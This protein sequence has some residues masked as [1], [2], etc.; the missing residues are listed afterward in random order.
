MFLSGLKQLSHLI[1]MFN[2]I[3]S[4]SGLVVA[5]A[6]DYKS[7]KLEASK[8]RRQ[9]YIRDWKL[10]QIKK[11]KEAPVRVYHDDSGCCDALRD[12]SLEIYGRLHW[13]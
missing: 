11:Q 1:Q 10:V 6:S 8:Y 9:E 5:K 2:I 3:D 7:A 4:R 13:R 12:R